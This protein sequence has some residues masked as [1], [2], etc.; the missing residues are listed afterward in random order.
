MTQTAQPARI[1]VRPAAGRIGAEILGVDLRGELDDAT[2]AGIRQAVLT[3]RVVFFRDQHIDHARHVAFGRRFGAL[4]RREGKKH[5]VH[6]EGHPEILTVD[7]KA[8]V[9]RYGADFEEHY[10]RKWVSPLAGWHSDLTQFVNPPDMS[11]LRAEKTPEFGGDTQ[12][13]NTV[14][15]YEGLS[16]PLRALVDGLTAEHAFFN[17]VTLRHSD[18]RDREILKLFCAEPQVAVHPV[19]RVHPETGEK[20]LFVSPGSTTRIR[21]FSELES[22]HLL[23]LLFQH[24]TSAEYTVRFRWEPDSI[25][26][27]DNRST[28]HFAPTDFA[29]LDV[30][31]VM[32]RVTVL[33]EPA[34]GPDGFVSEAVAGQ[35]MRAW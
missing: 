28:C 3:H 5:G 24:L 23:D 9:E 35:P 34:K 18:E 11:I 21:G 12:W 13:T 22:R 20:G 2:V 32:H 26:F 8:D 30:D 19:V 17:A 7:P 10:R 33:G 14:A 4:T 6:P 29:H 1:T 27:W 31:R 25:A 16:A 15:A